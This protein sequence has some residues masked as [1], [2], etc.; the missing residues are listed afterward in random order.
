M[1][2]AILMEP[3]SGAS[4]STANSFCTPWLTIPMVLKTF[5]GAKGM[6]SNCEAPKVGC[7]VNICKC[8]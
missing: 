8:Q 2:H 3:A 4:L 5:T 6:A 7:V 1:N